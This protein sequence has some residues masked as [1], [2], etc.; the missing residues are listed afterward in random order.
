MNKNII[1]RLQLVDFV[2]NLKRKRKK[3][4]FTNGVFDILHRGHI[5]Y[6]IKAKS[7][8]DILIVGL[9]SD[10]SVKRL[11]GK[12]RPIQ[13]QTDRAIILLGLEAVDYVTI[14]S[15][16]TPQKI[17]E[18][19]TPH[20]LAKGADY[21]ISEIVGADYVKQHGGIVKKIKLTKGRSSSK[22]IKLAN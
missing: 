12:S 3:I 10:I 19:I 5:E 8:G 11:K 6:L 22:I 9:N 4:V 16:D 20:I 17:I 21:K 2:K 13:N 18:L 14:F 7:M 1:P 15:E